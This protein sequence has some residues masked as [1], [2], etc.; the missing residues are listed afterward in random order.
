MLKT[1]VLLPDDGVGTGGV[2]PDSPTYFFEEQLVEAICDW[3]VKKPNFMRFNFQHKL[4]FSERITRITT[5][6]IFIHL[7]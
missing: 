2:L 1:P 4:S 3:A 5:N 7:K 6:Y